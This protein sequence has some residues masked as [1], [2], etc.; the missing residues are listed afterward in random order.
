MG[1]YH[2]VPLPVWVL[3]CC[4]STSGTGT[5]VVVPLPVRVLLFSLWINPEF[6]CRD[7][8]RD[9][10]TLFYSVGGTAHSCNTS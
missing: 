8:Y 5:Y 9:G 3:L 7:I 6:W 2:V 1:T 4:C 10:G